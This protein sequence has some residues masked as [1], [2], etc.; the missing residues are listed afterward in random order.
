[1]VTGLRFQSRA[2]VGGGDAADSADFL[3]LIHPRFLL[4]KKTNFFRFEA[5]GFVDLKFE[6]R[7]RIAVQFSY[8]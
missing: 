8:C 5:G 2:A 4:L 1:M 3:I 6:F 7:M